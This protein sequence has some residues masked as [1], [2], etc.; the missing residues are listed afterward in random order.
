M[1][2][3]PPRFTVQTVGRFPAQLDRLIET[4]RQRGLRTLLAE[5]L[6]EIV[7]HLQTR[8]REWGDPYTNY[9]GL[10]AVGYEQTILPAG[11]RVKYAVHETE[12]VVWL[13]MIRPLSG[14]PFA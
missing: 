12:P 11:L 8:P 3:T 10:N 13:S 14:S 6:R 9:R 1:N 5:A 7:E 4:A 2:P